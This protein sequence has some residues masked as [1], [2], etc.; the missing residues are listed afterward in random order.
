MA[1]NDETP[2]Q[3]LQTGSIQ[4]VVTMNKSLNEGL[5]NFDSLERKGHQTTDAPPPQSPPQT[6]SA[7][8]PY[9]EVLAAPP[10]TPALEPV[11]EPPAP[12]PNT[13]TT[14]ES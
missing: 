14:G 6:I 1:E 9:E 3:R 8:F 2:V 13:E 12:V 7:I 4:E 10:I 11:K 5:Q